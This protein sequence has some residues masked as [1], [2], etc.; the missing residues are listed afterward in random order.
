MA[1][2][3]GELTASIYNAAYMVR[4]YQRGGRTFIGRE[5]REKAIRDMGL[6]IRHAFNSSED[7][8][9]LI[10]A[11]ACGIFPKDDPPF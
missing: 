1:P 11:V 4:H 8:A 9:P 6:A 3:T 2:D 7:F 10:A 5:S